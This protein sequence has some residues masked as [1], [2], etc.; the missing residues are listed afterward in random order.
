[1]KFCKA[2]MLFFTFFT[3]NN[4]HVYASASR[5]ILRAVSY[6]AYH[7]LQATIKCAKIGTKGF[8]GCCSGYLV[9]R[10]VRKC[11]KCLRG[12]EFNNPSYQRALKSAFRGVGLA[13]LAFECGNS[14]V[15]DIKELK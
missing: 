12:D 2:T 4:N 5:D 14:L 13:L 7:P 6:I 11:I 1:M 9:W 15:D 10:E 3:L 8:F